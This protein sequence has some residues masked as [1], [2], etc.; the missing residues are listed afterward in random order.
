ML[1]RTFEGFSCSILWK[2][3]VTVIALIFIG[4]SDIYA[5]DLWNGFDTDMEESVAKSELKKFTGSILGN[6]QSLGLELPY[7]FPECNNRNFFSVCGKDTPQEII[8]L[9]FH[10]ERLFAVNVHW[11]AD[12]QDVLARARTQYGNPSDTKRGRDLYG[13]NWV[14]Y[15][16][17]QAE[18]YFIIKIIGNNDAYSYFI[19]RN[20]TEQWE[21]ESAKLREEA[22][23][24]DD[25]R[26]KAA[27]EG[28]SF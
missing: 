26:K 13:N 19:D 6:Y 18:R 5:I 7:E 23:A 1:K 12:G 28:I 22:Q 21:K 20:G 27:T 24:A 16:W 4:Y 8:R 3:Q 14:V 2:F 15:R 9:Y 25:A 11:R 10:N 17:T